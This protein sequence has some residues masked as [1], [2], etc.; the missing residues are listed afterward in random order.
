[1]QTAWVNPYV[2]AAPGAERPDHT[3][4]DLWGLAALTGGRAPVN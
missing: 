3:W 1:M 2:E 4:R